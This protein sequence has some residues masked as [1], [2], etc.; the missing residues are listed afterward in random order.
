[1]VIVLFFPITHSS[2]FY[3]AVG[4]K[5]VKISNKNNLIVAPYSRIN[6]FYLA[7]LLY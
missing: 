6:K 4:R 5:M 7:D 1:M 3:M 2:A